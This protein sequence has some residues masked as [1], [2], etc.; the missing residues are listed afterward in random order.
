VCRPD[1]RRGC[2]GTEPRCAR[3]QQRRFYDEH[4]RDYDRWMRFYDPLMLGDARRRVCSLASGRTLELAVGTWVQA[5]GIFATVVTRFFGWWLLGSALLGLG[6]AMVY[7]SLIAA[8]SDN[9][10][11]AWALLADRTGAMGIVKAVDPVQ[12]HRFCCLSRIR[13]YVKR[14]VK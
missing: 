10:H 2:S 12:Y 8:V 4:A 6:T 5:A 13:R 11:P 1:T 7:P 14:A 3:H 9:S